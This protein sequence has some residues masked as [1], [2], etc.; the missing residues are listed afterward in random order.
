[1]WPVAGTDPITD[2]PLRAHRAVEDGRIAASLTARSIVH[3]GIAGDVPIKQLGLVTVAVG[4]FVDGAR[5][6]RPLDGLASRLV[7]DVG[8]GIRLGLAGGRMGVLSID[9]ATS[10]SDDRDAL[11]L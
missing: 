2:I 9:F 7:A 11:S 8:G 3:G 1:R 6:S 10:L 4:A 5:V